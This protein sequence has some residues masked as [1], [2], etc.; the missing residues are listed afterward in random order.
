MIESASISYPASGPAGRQETL[1]KSAT[2]LISKVFYLLLVPRR[3]RGKLRHPLANL[4]FDWPPAAPTGS[5]F[6]PKLDQMSVFVLPA[7]ILMPFPKR[8]SLQRSVAENVGTFVAG[9][10]LELSPMFGVPVVELPRRLF[11]R[12]SIERI[13]VAD[14]IT[15]LFP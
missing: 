10:D 13:Q 1:F 3:A 9:R 4:H 12:G 11:A 7:F 6:P 8:C 2:V 5:R 15:T 14:G